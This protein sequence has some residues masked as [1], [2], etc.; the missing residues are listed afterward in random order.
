MI[1]L[2]KATCIFCGEEMRVDGA[3]VYRKITCWAENN[4]S[5]RPSKIVKPVDLQQYAHRVCFETKGL[6]PAVSLF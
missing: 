2:M 5:G 6:G 1:G 3:G 4:K